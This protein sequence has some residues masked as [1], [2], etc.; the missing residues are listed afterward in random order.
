M[1]VIAHHE[2]MGTEVTG[3]FVPF[4]LFLGSTPN[5]YGYS[6]NHVTFY[7]HVVLKIVY[8]L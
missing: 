6:C 5:G 8:N 4:Q 2:D 7:Q 1:I 3:T